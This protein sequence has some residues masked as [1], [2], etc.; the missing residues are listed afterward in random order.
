MPPEIRLLGIGSAL[1]AEE[2]SNERLGALL[3]SSADAIADRTGI[4]TRRW[5]SSGESPSSLAARAAEQA[6][7]ASATAIDRVGLIIFA[8][9]TPDV[10]FPGAACF[11]QEKLGAPTVGALDVRAQTAGFICALDLATAFATLSAPNG[12]IDDR[13]ERVLVAAGEV[14][15]SGLDESPRGQ[16]MTPRFGDGA[17]VAIVGRGDVGPR[18]VS[19]R[20][21]TE[22]DLADRFW[23]E[24]PASRQ[25]PMR[26]TA[27]DLAAGKHF[28][29]ADLAGIA[30]IVRDRLQAIV[31]EV[32]G[33]AGWEPN[34]IDRLIIDYIDPAVA[35]GAAAGLGIDPARVDVPTARLGHVMAGGLA[36]ALAEVLPRLGRGT[37][38]LLAGAGSG[39]T[40]GAAAL[41]V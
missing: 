26:V 23:C 7:S 25:A 29:R 28:P 12:A 37:R 5:A 31:R 10:C 18:L 11:L 21:Y 30:P 33:V 1:P 2:V 6:L 19:V 14:H 39:L 35:R 9:A 16:D 13:Y 17:G 3:G 41:E 20:W 4:E 40:Y 36:I 8:T 27:A 15:S 24:Y 22:G 34:Q 32:I 38:V